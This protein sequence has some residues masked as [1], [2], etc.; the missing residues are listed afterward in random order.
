VDK[1]IPYDMGDVDSLFYDLDKHVDI[2]LLN[3]M[4]QDY[5][6]MLKQQEKEEGNNKILGGLPPLEDEEEDLPA[7]TLMRGN[8]EIENINQNPVDD[9]IDEEIDF[10]GLDNLTLRRTHN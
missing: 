5:K 2:G 7:P 8:L 10:L 4:Y 6:A 9:N 3:K 1:N